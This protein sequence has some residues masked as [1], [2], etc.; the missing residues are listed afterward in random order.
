[1]NGW[2]YFK[3]NR[4]L[5]TR[6]IA[7]SIA[8][9]IWS[10]CIPLCGLSAHAEATSRIT[11]ISIS[12]NGELLLQVEGEGF[13]PQLRLEPT[14][15]G[16][17]RI[18]VQG[19]GVI[20]SQEAM[21]ANSHLGADLSDKI[22]AIDKATLSAGADESFQLV[23]TAWRKLQPQ[24][25]SNNGNQIVISLN[26]DHSVPQAVLWRLQQEE[27]QRLALLRQQEAL[28]Q[29][30]LKRQEA[31]KQQAAA[32]REAKR[33][34]E[35]EQQQLAA[36][37]QQEAALRNAK[38][39]EAAE[40]QRLAELQ[41]LNMGGFSSD[42]QAPALT[43]QELY[44][45]QRNYSQFKL[46]EARRLMEQQQH[47]SLKGQQLHAITDMPPQ[48]GRMGNI[49]QLSPNP[50]SNQPAFQMKSSVSA[51]STD[52]QKAYIAQ[53]PKSSDEVIAQLQV[54]QQALPTASRNTA[55]NNGYS[56]PVTDQNDQN[57]DQP[58]SPNRNVPTHFS[59]PAS[60]PEDDRDSTP[61]DPLRLKK[62]PSDFVPE[63]E[64]EAEPEPA[65]APVSSVSKVLK[66][67]VSH[68]H[69]A[70]HKTKARVGQPYMVPERSV[71]RRRTSSGDE[72][73]K[74]PSWD[75][76]YAVIN[77]PDADPILLSAW[78]SLMSGKATAAVAILRKQL[79]S[80]SDNRKVQS[81]T[82]SGSTNGNTNA[83]YLL[84]EILLS[85]LLETGNPASLKASQEREERQEEAQEILLK[86]Y[87][88]SLHWPS[89]QA[90]VELFLEG[91][92]LDEATRLLA[93]VKQAYPEEPGVAYEQG[94]LQE[95][96]D[97]LNAARGAYQKA[98]IL[99]PE[100]P[101][102]HYRLAQVELKSGHLDAARW[103]LLQALSRSPNDSRLYKLLGYIA[104][105]TGQTDQAANAYRQALP[106]DALINY[107]R[108]LQAQNQP[109]KAFNMYQ[110][111]EALAG[112]DGDLL[113]NLAMI[114]SDTNHP[115]QATAVLQRFLAL[116]T[117]QQ[118]NR[119]SKAKLLLKRLTRQK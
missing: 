9:S 94:R 47:Q 74:K 62:T 87:E 4:S 56:S 22:P 118:D 18:V 71:K 30:E 13:D 35:V 114:Y 89:C 78:Q 73:Q 81:T 31:L 10:S 41:G 43:S 21:Q 5:E 44:E 38:Q 105:K 24:V 79:Q 53:K 29:Q 109:E 98:L 113:Y 76:I 3:R 60:E 55:S 36:L 26:G 34:R 84:A 107:A 115:A 25:T 92:K 51:S 12:P 1:M 99:Q 100:N 97:D 33:Q 90:L 7:A 108:T 101:E 103:E 67:T 8:L 112:N 28:H 19:S 58:V 77:R 69:P 59:E 119:L 32:L 102:I 85:P 72:G 54:A 93:Q 48:N 11:E 66:Q 46:Q 57:N 68:L 6:W 65:P 16:E 52:W 45:E 95:A 49:I 83:R 40:Q 116:D 86:N 106:V 50:A 96:L 27:Q 2:K 111:V 64:R 75:S 15:N 104:E 63:S 23:L 37:I 88:Q 17:F 110:A 14:G 80:E 61:T 117:A 42:G 39:Q 82:Q 70:K 91:G 20:L